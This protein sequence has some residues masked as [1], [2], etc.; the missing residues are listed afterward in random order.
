MLHGELKNVLTRD[1]RNFR[2]AHTG[3]LAFWETY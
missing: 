3:I 1:N 2:E